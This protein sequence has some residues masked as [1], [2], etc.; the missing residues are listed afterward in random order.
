MA[1]CTGTLLPAALVERAL[2]A[3][4]DD[5]EAFDEARRQFEREYLTQH[6]QR[7]PTA[8]SPRRPSSPSATAATSIRC[9]RATNSIPPQFKPGKE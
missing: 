8:T 4:G 5:F 7:S 1:L 6:P 9:S 2:A 3:R